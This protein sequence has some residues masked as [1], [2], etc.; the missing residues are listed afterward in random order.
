MVRRHDAKALSCCVSIAAACS[1]LGNEG[2]YAVSLVTL[3]LARR[4]RCVESH[5]A[6]TFMNPN[7]EPLP[8][9]DYLI[10]PRLTPLKGGGFWLAVVIEEDAGF[11]GTRMHVFDRSEEFKTNEE[12]H[13]AGLQ[14]GQRLIDEN[15]IPKK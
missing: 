13:A 14:I 4:L 11:T 5:R 9:G 3:L 10:R 6:G 12:A 7:L 1:C 2:H 8:Y 15:A